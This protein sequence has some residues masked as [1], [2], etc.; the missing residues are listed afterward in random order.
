MYGKVEIIVLVISFI[1]FFMSV[2]SLA[3]S[4]TVET[5]L[6]IEPEIIILDP[7]QC[8]G[9]CCVTENN[10]TKTLNCLG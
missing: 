7:G 2:I 1:I 4:Q 3:Q 8:L 10:D 5:K 6:T 9:D